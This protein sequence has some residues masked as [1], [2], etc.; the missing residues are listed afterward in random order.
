[1]AGWNDLTDAEADRQA[2]IAKSDTRNSAAQQGVGAD[3]A[4]LTLARRGSTPD[5]GRTRPRQS[6]W[7]KISAMVITSGRVVAG[8]IVVDGEPLPE[9]AVVTVLAR[10]GDETFELDAAAEAELLASMAEG[11]RG[12]TIP[13]EDVLRALRDQHRE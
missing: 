9:G 7:V 2:S 11:D 3:G 10:E 13:A 1:L 6:I 12:Q 5:V 4:T 8:K